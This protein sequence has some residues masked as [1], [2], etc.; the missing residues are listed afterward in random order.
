VETSGR[1]GRGE[2]MKITCEIDWID[3]EATI[4][5]VLKNEVISKVVEHIAL[6]FNNDMFK[7]VEKKASKE[8]ARKADSL[9]E[10]LMERFTNKEIRVTD[11]WGDIKEEYENVNEL[12]KGKFDGFLTESVDGNGKTASSCSYG[13]TY[14]RLEYVL[15]KRIKEQSDNLTKEI[16]STVDKKIEEQKKAI[17]Q[18][19]IEKIAK[20][21]NLEI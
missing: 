7:E 4:D 11:A 15:D 6:K 5:D 10:R 21:L 13:K 16:V 17:H 8:L 1:R 9:M 3:E 18:Q 2:D 12:L 20:K 14:T 19:A